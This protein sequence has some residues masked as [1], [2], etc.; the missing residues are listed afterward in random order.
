[1]MGAINGYQGSAP[2]TSGC[3]FTVTVEWPDT[4]SWWNIE[5]L[6]RFFDRY[7]R[8]SAT[9]GDDPE[10][11]LDIMDAY[12]FDAQTTGQRRL[13]IAHTEYTKFYWTPRGRQLRDA[14]GASSAVTSYD[15]AS[16]ESTFDITFT[17]TPRSPGSSRPDSGSRPTG[18]T[19]W[20][21][22]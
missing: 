2:S 5:D 8:A 6:T 17:R 20:T 1:M 7:S 11:R 22:S 13:P 15:P 19:R 9:A 21:C 16:G 10:G 12:E 4:Y 3:G 18:T 14:P